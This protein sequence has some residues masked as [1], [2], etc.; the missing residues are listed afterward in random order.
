M[1]GR[2]TIID[3]SQ[4]L[5]WLLSFSGFCDEK[6][7]EKDKRVTKREQIEGGGCFSSV[8]NNNL[9]KILCPFFMFWKT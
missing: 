2:N 8:C 1:L 9:I 5:F 6:R 7:I 3:T 4:V